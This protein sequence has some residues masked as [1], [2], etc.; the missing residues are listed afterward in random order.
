VRVHPY[1]YI[2]TYIHAV[3]GLGFC[4]EV[5]KK[6]EHIH[7]SVHAHF[8]VYTCMYV[9][10][11]VCMYVCMYVWQCMCV[12]MY[13]HTYNHAAKALGFVQS[14]AKE[15]MHIHTDTD[16]YIHLYICT[17]ILT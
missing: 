15:R 16:T 10:M 12:C 7:T 2:H 9:F 3:K 13:T 14:V 11:Y 8:C 1:T 17:H 5:R 6:W 4:E